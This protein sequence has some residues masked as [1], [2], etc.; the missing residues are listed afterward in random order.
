MAVAEARVAVVAGVTAVETDVGRAR[1]R[2]I[3]ELVVS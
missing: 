2:K 1:K 3:A